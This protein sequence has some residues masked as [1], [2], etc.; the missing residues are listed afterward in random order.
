MSSAPS[1]RVARSSPTDVSASSATTDTSVEAQVSCKRRD[2]RQMP[3]V[4]GH[5]QRFSRADG[6]L[7][8][9]PYPIP[10]PKTEGNYTGSGR[11]KRRTRTK[12]TKPVKYN[13]IEQSRSKLQQLPD[14][15]H[16]QS[17][18]IPD[19]Q[20]STSYKRPSPKSETTRTDGPVSETPV[21]IVGGSG[22][23]PKNAKELRPTPLSELQSHP[24]YRAIMAAPEQVIRI[25]CAHCILL[26]IACFI[27]DG[28][29][30]SLTKACNPCF[31]R[32]RSIYCSYEGL[33][34]ETTSLGA[35]MTYMRQRST[36]K[37]D[38]YNGLFGTC[39]V[40]G[41]P[42][43][44][45]TT[46]GCFSVV[47]RTCADFLV[48]LR[49]RHNEL[50]MSLGHNSKNKVKT[51]QRLRKHISALRLRKAVGTGPFICPVSLCPRTSHG[52]LNNLRKHI[53][54]AHPESDHAKVVEASMFMRG[55]AWTQLTSTLVLHKSLID[56][57]PL[58]HLDAMLCNAR[59][60]A[61]G[62][63]PEADWELMSYHER[64]R[65]A[66]AK[67][68]HG[69][70]GLFAPN[71]CGNCRKS[72]S[73]CLLFHPGLKSGPAGT[74]LGTA[75]GNCRNG[76]IERS[77]L[78]PPEPFGPYVTFEDTTTP[79]TNDL[80]KTVQSEY[81]TPV[82]AVYTYKPAPMEPNAGSQTV[83]HQQQ[84]PPLRNVLRDLG[85]TRLIL[86]R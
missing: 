73:T 45:F 9:S 25:A 61:Y 12:L 5:K 39:P 22:S 86:G 82:A 30:H 42:S 47:F 32:N 3:A 35:L 11:K 68:I 53:R 65:I 69:E 31:N 57:I 4:T 10:V 21:I 26:G 64:F 28:P 75:C 78:I 79:N 66:Y 56:V 20:G 13:D 15:D 48:H 7:D 46:D 62:H 49:E 54:T 60:G 40:D 43:A 59:E 16:P 24:K 19:V 83:G 55:F 8:K 38:E 27:F 41:C 51:F 76:D 81:K 14:D 77:C 85:Y 1:P 67:L 44:V 50:A 29:G 23:E 52:A 58:H 37:R 80:S 84:L 72:N 63:R 71:A 74:A 2:E 70:Y 34:E 18:H 17:G 6:F 33:E 36:L